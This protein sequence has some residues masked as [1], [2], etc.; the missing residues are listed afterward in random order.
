MPLVVD[1]RTGRVR[2]RLDRGVT[3]FRG[4]PF[5]R[6]PIGPLR[7]AAP[8]AAPRRGAGVRECAEPAPAAPQNA[9]RFAPVL[10]E[11][12]EKQSEDC[13]A[14]DLWTAG[15]E[16][17]PRPVLVFVHG[18]DFAEGATSE[19]CIRGRR[20]AR[21]GD[22]VVVSLSVPPRRARAS[23]RR[24]SACSTWWRGSSGC[25][26]RSTPSAA[27]RAESPCSATARAQPPWRACSPCARARPLFQRAILASGRYAVDSPERAEARRAAFLRDA[28]PRCR[29]TPRSWRESRSRTCSGAQARSRRL[30]PV[31]DGA[32]LPAA[33]LDAAARRPERRRAAP[34]RH[35]ERRD[36]R[37][38]LR[39]PGAARAAPRRAARAARSRRH[40]PRR[41][42]LRRGAGARARRRAARP[43]PPR[44]H[45]APLPRARAPSR[46]VTLGARRARLPVPLRARRAPRRRRH[47]RVSRPRPAAR[48][49][50]AARDSARPVSSRTSPDAKPVGRRMRDAWTAFARSGDPRAPLPDWPRYTAADRATLVFSG[51]R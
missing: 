38:R 15:F 48:V 35:G 3:A 47:R 26:T 30:P 5:A 34:D 21:G 32:L 7:F 39:R 8:A 20:L 33:P 41:G 18:G 6:A 10:G 2:G 25:A 42:R 51:S 43:L 24:T 9:S 16:G 22:L 14:L 36:A 46:R 13:L 29:A 45:G 40:R 12:A 44:R 49:R 4:M 23:S 19:P 37:A 50:H 11:R 17:V 27:T 28:R 31:V 1:T